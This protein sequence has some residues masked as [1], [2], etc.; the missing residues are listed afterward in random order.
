MRKRLVTVGLLVS[1]VGSPMAL[2]QSQQGGYLGENPGAHITSA[3]VEQPQLGSV[4]GG[5]L[6]KNIGAELKPMVRSGVSGP[7]SSPAAWCED[8]LDPGRCRSRAA[9]DHAWCAE[10]NPGHYASCRQTMDYIG[11]HN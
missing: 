5:Y 1:L 6:G 8:S 9:D 4:Q 10:H 2:A 3:T 7:T 11:W